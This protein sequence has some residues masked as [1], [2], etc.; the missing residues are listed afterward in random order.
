MPMRTT[1]AWELGNKCRGDSSRFGRDSPTRDRSPLPRRAWEWDFVQHWRGHVLHAMVTHAE[2]ARLPCINQR[3]PGEYIHY[4]NCTGGFRWG[5][6]A[7]HL[8][9]FTSEAGLLRVME[10]DWDGAVG[11]ITHPCKTFIPELYSCEYVPRRV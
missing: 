4:C 9:S 11:Y 2:H 7:R 1:L 6:D 3:L 8:R 5:V 10:T